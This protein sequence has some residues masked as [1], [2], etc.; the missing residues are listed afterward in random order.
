M[1]WQC[2]HWYASFHLI[3]RNSAFLSRWFYWRGLYFLPKDR[4]MLEGT[5]YQVPTC[6]SERRTSV[7]L[8]VGSLVGSHFS[9]LSALSPHWKGNK[10][11]FISH[12]L[13]FSFCWHLAFGGRL[14]WCLTCT[15][16]MFAELTLPQQ[17]PSFRF[18]EGYCSLVLAL[19]PS[20]IL[21]CLL[22]GEPCYQMMVNRADPVIFIWLWIFTS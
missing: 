14:I 16:S 2:K 11:R 7:Q 13:R 6:F 17:M 4:K 22:L 1:E 19:G 5:F 12:S 3:M 8:I 20:I 18:G 9:P 15:Q 10:Q 21:Q